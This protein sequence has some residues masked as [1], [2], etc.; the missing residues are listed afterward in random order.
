MTLRVHLRVKLTVST[1]SS[2]LDSRFSKPFD[3][4]QDAEECCVTNLHADVFV[5]FL[6]LLFVHQNLA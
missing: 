1:R 5:S 2:I 6:S 3:Q 4:S